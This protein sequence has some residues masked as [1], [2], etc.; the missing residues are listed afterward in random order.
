MVTR[1]T[2]LLLLIQ[3]AAA[4]GIGTAIWRLFFLPHAWQGML[5][6]LGIVLL[7]RLLINANNFLMAWRHR[8]VT[9]EPHI[10][11]WRQ[12]CGMFAEEFKSSMLTSSWYMPFFS[13]SKKNFPD[14][15][16]L[17]VLLIHGYG[18]NSGY[19]HHL[20]RKLS[21]AKIT[22]HAV[23]LEPVFGEIDDY[24][25]AIHAAIETLRRESGQQQVVIVAHSMGGL[26]ARAYLSKHGA[27]HIA[28]IITL[29]VPHHGTGLAEVGIG[30][31]SDQMRCTDD[32]PNS[33]LRQLAEKEN[34]AH[35]ALFVNIFSHHDNIVS[36][37]T[38]SCLNGA[39]NLAV[40]GIGHVSLA[41]HPKTQ[42]MVMEE[43]L[44][45]GA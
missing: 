43:I 5:L 44:N 8:S 37:Q 41:F 25:P 27:A 24:I 45:A 4:I 16:N 2:R 22:H 40:S 34:P 36:P 30:K 18:C 33:W 19:W 23:D 3:L 10:L 21:A 12:A 42:A 38:S 39:R 35:Y 32:N 11:N 9:P 1:L 28:R 17:S 13:I 15:R 20:S 31:N 7:V 14:T 29:G 6:G 26:V